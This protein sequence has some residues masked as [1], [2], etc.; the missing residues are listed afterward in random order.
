MLT[1]PQRLLAFA[2]VTLALLTG[3]TPVAMAEGNV[4]CTGIG[5]SGNGCSSATVTVV[6]TIDGQQI[7]TSLSGDQSSVVCRTVRGVEVGSTMV[8]PC[9]T[10]AGWWSGSRNCY[11]K[12]AAPQPDFSSPVWEGHTTGKI[13]DC[14]LPAGV[15]GPG[16]SFW[17]DTPP[18]STAQVAQLAA[19]AVQTLGLTAVDI[20]MAPTPTSLDPT[21][22]GIVGLPN[23]MWVKNPSPR[24]YGPAVGSASS[25]GVTVTVT[26]KVDRVTWTMGDGTPPIVCTTAGTPYAASYGGAPSPDCGHTP[27]Y[28]KQ[29]TY[30][31]T[32]DSHWAISYSS[33]VGIGGTLAMN[34]TRSSS[35]TVGELQ[36]AVVPGR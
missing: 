29:G 11:V 21:S 15:G 34:L 14:T 28:Q 26:A 33:N 36:A 2:T 19:R 17:S 8:V 13:Y 3:L 23:W 27:G 6:I 30:R 35:I 32:A 18:V 7:E 5:A 24:T 31:V 9:E 10:S 4:Q 22:I 12:L 16:L 20:G 25:G 1:I